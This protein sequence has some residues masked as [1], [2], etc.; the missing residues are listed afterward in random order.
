MRK[1]MKT[2]RHRITAKAVYYCLKNLGNPVALKRSALTELPQVSALARRYER[3]SWARAYALRDLLRTTCEQ[4]LA[5][6]IADQR[7]EKVIAFLRLFLET[8]NV[9]A[10]SRTL[11]VDRKSLYVYIMPQAFELVIDELQHTNTTS[12]V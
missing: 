5:V 9:S 7:Q 11:G 3:S 1:E 6:E 4:I 10:I 12:T 8:P 2:K